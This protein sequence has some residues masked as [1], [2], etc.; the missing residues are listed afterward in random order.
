[1]S[2]EGSEKEVPGGSSSILPAEKLEDKGFFV[3]RMKKS[4]PPSSVVLRKKKSQPPFSVLRSKKSAPPPSSLL[5]RRSHVLSPFFRPIFDT[6]SGP[7]IEIRPRRSKIED[8][9]GKIGVLRSSAPKIEDGSIRSSTPKNE[10]RNRVL[11]R[12]PLL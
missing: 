3:L 2:G 9:K 11:R 5:G 1:M 10:E 12:N 6:F 8:G 4:R 7:K